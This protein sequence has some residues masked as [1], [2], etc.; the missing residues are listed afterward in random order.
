MP[1][2]PFNPN[3]PFEPAKPAFNPSAHYEP[4]LE[5]KQRPAGSVEDTNTNN[6]LPNLPP[7]KNI[8]GPVTE[9]N[10]LMTASDPTHQWAVDAAPSAGLSGVNPAMNWATGLIGRGAG[11]VGD[12]MLQGAVGL[13]KYVPGLGTQL[14][15]EGV[16]GT[17][18]MMRD[19]V[20]KGLERRGQEIGSLAKGINEV[21]T[22][23]ASQRVLSKA[24]KHVQAD[25]YVHPEDLKNFEYL[26]G[27][28]DSIA[29]R[30]GETGVISGE[31]AASARSSA[32]AR[33]RQAGAYRDNPSE[34]MKAQAA[35]AEQGG[36]SQAL[37]DAY[38]KANPNQPNLLAEADT[39]Y[40]SLAQAS[41]ALSQPEKLSSSVAGLAAKTGLGALIGYQAGGPEGAIAGAAFGTPLAQSAVART[42]IGASK[43]AKFLNPALAGTVQEGLSKKQ[44]Q[45]RK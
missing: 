43:L 38:A 26:Q 34:I 8:K 16:I 31:A 7:E 2:P 9:R 35:K 19:Q 14:A 13:K 39:A 30:G 22:D 21:P 42:A 45:R 3:Q 6:S 1:K 25:G 12:R 4:V 28:A 44:I 24:T 41:K 18:N 27:S 37:K 10:E 40:G 36:W 33:A 15:E 32:G 23:V 17:R 29:S 5:A 11:Y 20:A